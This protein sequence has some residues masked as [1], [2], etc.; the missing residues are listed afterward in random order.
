MTL[1]V[2]RTINDGWRADA[3]LS[4]NIISAL[5]GR[6]YF[7]LA[8]LQL[9]LIVLLCLLIGS[10]ALLRGLV[11]SSGRG[12]SIVLRIHALSLSVESSHLPSNDRWLRTPAM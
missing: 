7:G 8:L 5:G 6:N 2:F 1:A 10:G 12:R 9:I 11:G 4:P 3:P